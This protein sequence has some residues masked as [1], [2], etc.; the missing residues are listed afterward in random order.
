MATIMAM[1]SINEAVKEHGVLLAK[2]VPGQG[3]GLF[4][5]AA[6]Q[7]GA[8]IGKEKPIALQRQQQ[9]QKESKSAWKLA[10]NHPYAQAVFALVPL[11]GDLQD[12][13]DRNA[14]E[15]TKAD[16]IYATW[17]LCNHSCDPNAYIE[18]DTQ[19]G[20]AALVALK[21]IADQE[22]ITI[23]YVETETDTQTRRD[24]LLDGWGFT[25]ECTRCVQ[26]SAPAGA[27]A[28]SDGGATNFS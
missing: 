22:Q 18:L 8:V 15:G 9:Q 14:F 12:K 27:A 20:V 23:S 4:S 16:Y 28:A 19:T 11:D 3:R 25:C 5:L 21:P 24:Q 17:S 26:D 6:W 7:P 10:P 2:Y 13:C 1:Q